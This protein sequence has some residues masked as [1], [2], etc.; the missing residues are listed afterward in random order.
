MDKMGGFLQRMPFV[1]SAFL[2]AAM[3]GCG[4]PGFANFVGEAM[5]LFAAYQT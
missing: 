3:A 4:L 2:I 1:G 5:T